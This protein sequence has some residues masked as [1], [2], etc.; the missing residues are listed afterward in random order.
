[1]SSDN[2][3]VVESIP[4]SEKL[5]SAQYIDDV[6]EHEHTECTLTVFRALSQV[7]EASVIQT[8]AYTCPEI[9]KYK[10]KTI[11]INELQTQRLQSSQNKE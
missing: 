8:H 5:D 11:R 4:C 10:C 1:M 2:A 7:P 3:D 6:H 9:Q